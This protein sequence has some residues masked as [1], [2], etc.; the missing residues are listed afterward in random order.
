M[1]PPSAPAPPPPKPAA[2]ASIWVLRSVPRSRAW[3]MV[4]AVV[5]VLTALSCAVG[6]WSD[7]VTFSSSRTLCAGATASRRPSSMMS[8]TRTSPTVRTVSPFCRVSPAL[9][10]RLTP[11]ALTAKTVPLPVMAATVANWAMMIS[12]NEKGS[13]PN[14]LGH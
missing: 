6:R 5:V 1:A 13:L 10:A 14:W 3:M 4:S 2:G 9:R 7:S 12:G 11:C 8:S